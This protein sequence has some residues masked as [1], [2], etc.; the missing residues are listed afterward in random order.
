MGVQLLQRLDRA[1]G[2][3][4]AVVEP[5][6]AYAGAA[7]DRV[8]RHFGEHLAQLGNFSLVIR[9]LPPQVLGTISMIWVDEV[10][11][12][13]KRAYVRYGVALLALFVVGAVVL[14]MSRMG[15]R[16]GSHPGA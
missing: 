6:P 14:Q 13:E 3:G 10:R 11:A 15:I 2:E 9:D 4:S 7:E 8:G 5:E 16:L 12:N 1:R